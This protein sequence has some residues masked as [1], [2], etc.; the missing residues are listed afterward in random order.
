LQKRSQSVSVQIWRR[1]N[2][3]INI[4]FAIATSGELW[5]DEK[6]GPSPFSNCERRKFMWADAKKV[7]RVLKQYRREWAENAA[8]IDTKSGIKFVSLSRSLKHPFPLSNTDAPTHSYTSF[9][10]TIK[11]RLSLYL[12]CGHIAAPLSAQ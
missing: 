9:L 12:S 10:P 5:L 2:L 4:T 1:L 6:C 7:V 8:K 3:E 11:I